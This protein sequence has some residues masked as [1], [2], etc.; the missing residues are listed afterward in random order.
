MATSASAAGAAGSSDAYGYLGASILDDATRTQ[1]QLAVL[2]SRV[3]VCLVA[4]TRTALT[5]VLAAGH[6]SRAVRRGTAFF[7]RCSNLAVVSALAGV[8]CAC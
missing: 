7:R 5:S 6:S 8:A 1:D 4:A 3:K 2:R